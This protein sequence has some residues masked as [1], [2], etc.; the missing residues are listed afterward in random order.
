MRDKHRDDVLRLHEEVVKAMR[1]VLLVQADQID[2][3]RAKNDGHAYVPQRT[4]ALNPTQ[5]PPAE[6][7]GRKWLTEEEEEL[8]ALN[9]NGHLSDLE[10]AKLQADLGMPNLQSV[11]SLPDDD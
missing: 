3:L 6:S 7:G 11:P 9:L 1:D 5:Q 4:V 10:L 2:Y 8:L